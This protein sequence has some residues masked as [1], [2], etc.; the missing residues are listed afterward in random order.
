MKK[1]FVLLI[2]LFTC[3]LLVSCSHKSGNTD[4]S[5]QNNTV[6]ASS[7]EQTQSVTTT[8]T[9]ADQAST[10]EEES[11]QVAVSFELEDQHGN[12][13]KMS[14]YDDKIVMLNFWQTW[15]GPCRAEIPTLNELYNEWGKNQKD[16][17]ILGVSNPYNEQN[18]R[19]SDLSVDE[20]MSF[21]EENDMQYPILFDLSG[22]LYSQYRITSFPTSIFIKDGKI[23]GAVPG[24]LQKE[25]LQDLVDKIKSG[26]IK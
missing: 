12:K 22:E 8:S 21:I 15:C 16:I 2:S 26:E 23:L 11:K 5:E 17:V 20:L 1:L 3:I 9:R 14:D 24:A 10:D 6:T 13:I 19:A 25:A 4:V 7:S 18:K